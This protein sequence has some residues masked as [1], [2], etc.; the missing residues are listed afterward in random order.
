MWRPHKHYRYV[1]QV[2]NHMSASSEMQILTFL[3]LC[4]TLNLKRFYL[5]YSKF[6]NCSVF[7][8]L[9]LIEIGR[10]CFT[11]TDISSMF[12]SLQVLHLQIRTYFSWNLVTLLHNASHVFCIHCI[13]YKFTYCWAPSQL[14][15]LLRLQVG[16]PRCTLHIVTSVLDKWGNYTSNVKTAFKLSSSW[17]Y[18]ES[19]NWL[20]VHVCSCKPVICLSIVK[21][22]LCLSIYISVCLSVY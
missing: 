22:C 9:S 15:Y 5:C 12:E 18:L 17:A 10:Y 1:S 4:D 8:F 20:W 16:V 19:Y 21:F 2:I 14:T 3:F 7:W 13:Q 11:C 6:S